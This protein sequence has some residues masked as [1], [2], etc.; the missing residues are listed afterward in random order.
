MRKI[1]TA[2]ILVP[3][4]SS[5]S[6]SRWRTGSRCWSPSTR[7]DQVHPAMALTLPLYELMLA[8]LIVGVVVGG[9]AAWIRQGKWRRAARLARGGG[10][11]AA[12]RGRSPQAAR[13]GEAR[14][15]VPARR[16]AAPSAAAPERPATGRRGRVRLGGASRG[17]TGPRQSVGAACGEPRL[18]GPGRV[19]ASVRGQN[20]RPEDARGARRGARG[21]RRL[22]GFVFFPPSP[23][24]VEFEAR[25][26]S[27][28]GARPSAQGGALGR[29]HDDELAASI[30]A[31]APDLLQLHGEETPERVAAVRARFGLPVMKALPIAER[32]D[33]VADPAL[34]QGGRPPDLRRACAARGDAAGRARPAVRLAP[35]R[36]LRGRRA[37]H[38]LG[39]ARCRQRGGGAA[40]HRRARRRCLLRRRARARREGPGQDPRLRRQGAA[41]R[42][43]PLA[44]PDRTASRA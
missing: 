1:V 42:P 2:L 9:I 44:A 25:A 22:V 12:R 27:A 37:V 15:A 7:F 34:R 4:A 33:L 41:R 38:A 6:P 24:H 31:L 10:A 17:W 3:L 40:H 26:R 13:A 30:E 32:A 16:R 5:S 18:Q 28:R 8:L 21:R 19:D 20:L 39:R 14:R 43:T 23:R 35:P 11:R 29:R 36:A